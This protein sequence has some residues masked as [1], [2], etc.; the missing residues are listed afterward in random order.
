MP[1]EEKKEVSKTIESQSFFILKINVFLIVLFMVFD[2]NDPE[3]RE[4]IKYFLAAAGL[5]SLIVL[6]FGKE[7]KEEDEEEPPKEDPG[8]GPGDG[9]KEPP[10]DP[11]KVIKYGEHIHIGNFG[12]P[13]N[14]LSLFNLEGK[15]IVS[16]DESTQFNLVRYNSSETGKDVY[17]GDEFRVVKRYN[18]RAS[19][20]LEGSDAFEVLD[21]V[22]FETIFRFTNGD[23]VGRVQYGD[24]LWIEKHHNDNKFYLGLT[25]GEA[26]EV[27]NDPS[28]KKTEMVIQRVIDEVIDPK[29]IINYGQRLHIARSADHGAKLSLLDKKGTEVY[30][31]YEDT[32]LTLVKE[33]GQFTGPVYYGDP[34]LVLKYWSHKARLKLNSGDAYE[35]QDEISYKTVMRIEGYY[36]TESGPVKYGEQIW[37]VKH[38]RNLLFDT[39]DK[40][41]LSLT[42]GKAQEVK[43]DPDEEKT[44][45]IFTKWVPPVA[46]PPLSVV[47]FGQLIKVARH[48]SPANRL[49][50]SF[51]KAYE[52][53]DSDEPTQLTLVKLGGQFTGQVHYG[54][55]VLVLKYWNNKARLRLEGGKA[56]E[57]D[58][59]VDFETTF[60]I[61]NGTKSGPLLHGDMF[62][63]EKAW[64]DDRYYLY[65]DTLDDRTK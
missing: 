24:L 37:I 50:L 55:Q 61:V 42:D 8:D 23:R 21:K 9:P 31:E 5:Y 10:I 51:G 19:L 48:D 49:G 65:N 2:K 18:S 6:F 58:D 64:K 32:Q 1:E 3:D 53:T 13:Q 14:R 38:D 41:Y 39:L 22:S 17:Y 7:K 33:G 44:K 57:V 30:H 16:S 59:Q 29:K 35:V 46:P 54:D 26:Q 52:T 11:A 56:Y 28:E 34:V 43:N 27:K 60:K 25:D 20:M 12:A 47:N 40:Y 36:G 63:L 4:Y 15:Q 62:W 45:M